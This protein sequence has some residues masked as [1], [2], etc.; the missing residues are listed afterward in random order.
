ME[1]KELIDKITRDYEEQIEAL[2]HD[3]NDRTGLKPWRVEVRKPINDAGEI[4]YTVK[5]RSNH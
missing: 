3:Y 4:E 2:L 1:P 5:I